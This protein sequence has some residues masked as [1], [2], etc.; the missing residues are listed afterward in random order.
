M[1]QQKAMEKVISDVKWL[2]EDEIASALRLH[3]PLNEKSLLK[4]AT[5][6]EDS[7]L[8]HKTNCIF[9]KRYFMFVTGTEKATDLCLP[10]FVAEVE[11]TMLGKYKLTR[12]G[13]YWCVVLN[14]FHHFDSE[15]ERREMFEEVKEKAKLTR[16]GMGHR[17]SQSDYTDNRLPTQERFDSTAFNGMACRTTSLPVIN[18]PQSVEEVQLKDVTETI[19]VFHPLPFGPLWQDGLPF[20]T[21][22][23]SMMSQPIN[24][25]ECD[26]SKGASSSSLIQDDDRELR[27]S[28]S[29][30]EEKQMCE[31]QRRSFSLSDIYRP[32]NSY[33]LTF[34]VNGF[35]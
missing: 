12:V 15:S 6:V 29:Y 8:S 31:T 30:T 34:L 23:P 17:R 28:V 14:T 16:K 18:I 13:K 4:V 19:P 10:L 33:L 21:G 24:I 35:K 27:R 25:N 1:Q 9:E 11:S 32:G 3:I 20:S 26:S 22:G 2:L 5:H 7:K